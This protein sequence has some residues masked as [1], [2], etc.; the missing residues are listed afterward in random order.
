MKY[1]IF[2]FVRRDMLKSIR[3]LECERFNS[4]NSCITFTTSADDTGHQ[5]NTRKYLMAFEISEANIR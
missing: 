2:T 4:S 3:R 1:S 5:K